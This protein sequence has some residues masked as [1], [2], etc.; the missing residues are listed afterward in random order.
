MAVEE[1]LEA[2]VKDPQLRCPVE[3]VGEAAVS[4][5]HLPEEA[6]VRRVGVERDHGPMLVE[7]VPTSFKYELS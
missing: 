2:S 6:A 7:H 1:A 5:G 3:Q 4:D